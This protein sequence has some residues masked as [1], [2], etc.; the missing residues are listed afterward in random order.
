MTLK[1]LLRFKV[2]TKN[3]SPYN[4]G[5]YKNNFTTLVYAN[6]P[7]VTVFLSTYYR[8]VQTS[9]LIII[10]IIHKIYHL[11]KIQIKK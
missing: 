2:D 8:E 9:L 10:L 1:S 6:I 4:C 11:S 7:P 5:L 3:E